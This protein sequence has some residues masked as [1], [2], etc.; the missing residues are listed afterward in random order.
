MAALQYRP[1]IDGLRAIAVLSVFIFHL[2]HR[3]LPGGF[4]G[5]D[6]FFVISGYLITSIIFNDCQGDKFSLLKFYQRRIAR[7]FPAFFTVALATLV[8]ARFIY[9]PQDYASAGANLTAASLSVANLKYMLQG[10]YF[11]ISPD[12]QP[13]LHYW[14]LSVEEQFYLFFPLLFLLL[15]KYARNHLVLVLGILGSGSL[16]ACILLTPARPV[17]AFYLLPTRAWELCAG[18]L[19]AVVATHPSSAY[20]ETWRSWIPLVGLLLVVL[21]F[22]LLHEGPQFPG[23]RAILPVVGSV[24]LILPSAASTGPVE[25]WL[26]APP[27]VMIGR[28]SYSLYLWHWPVFSLVDYRLFLAPEPVRLALKIGLSFLAALCSFLLIETP[29]R[30]FLNQPKRRPIAF[31][32]LT[33]ALALCVPLGISIRRAN[34]VNAEFRDVANGGLVFPGKPGAPSVVLMGDSNGSMYGKVMKEICADLGYKL[35]VIS[36]A[37]GDPLPASNAQHGKLW[38][39]SLATVKKERP[40][41]LVLACHWSGKL[42]D[43]PDRLAL[44]LDTLR[45][46]VG[47]IVLLNQPPTLP[48]QANRGDIRRGARP[49]FLEDPTTRIDRKKANAFLLQFQSKVVSVVDISSNF[50]TQ[51]GAVSFLDGNGRQLYN[52]GSHLSSYGVGLLRPALVSAINV[53]SGG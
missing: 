18:S 25:K 32:A 5:V 9:T 30:R 7:I 6:V 19:M 37:A 45:P 26:A 27:L 49:P 16:L 11:Q 21:S 12:A 36:V 44:A 40:D 28:M 41:V 50:E 34:Y 29:V 1:A 43:D 8:G 39:D 23:W 10:S 46:H 38:L 15:F 33:A 31:A 22:F 35:T 42:A 53:P 52:D 13:F 4:V 47:R 14:S 3:W 2:N 17:W 51:E 48:R 24:A 20:N